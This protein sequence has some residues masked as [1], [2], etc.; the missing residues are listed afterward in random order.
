MIYKVQCY[1]CR[2]TIGPSNTQ[3]ILYIICG[4]CNELLG[5]VNVLPVSPTQ[6]TNG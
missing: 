6:Q 4:P 3:N 1:K 5:G 2:V